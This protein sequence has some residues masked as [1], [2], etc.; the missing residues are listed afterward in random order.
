MKR[1]TSSSPV[2]LF[3]DVQL[4]ADVPILLDGNAGHYLVN[5]MRCKEGDEIVLFNGF[6]GE[7]VATIVQVGK[8]KAR[9]V[10]DTQR[11]M[12]Q[13]E[14]DL[15]LLFAPIKKARLDY[16]IQKATEL[17]AS[18]IQAVLTQRTNLDRVKQDRMQANAI[19]AAEQCERMTVPEVREPVALFKVLEQWPDDRT[20]FFCDEGGNAMTIWAAG[21]EREKLLPKAAI[22]IGPEGGFSDDERAALRALPYV[23]PITLGPRILRADTAA[24]AAMALYQSSMG[25]WC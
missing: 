9:L 8:G 15:W 7:W 25:D 21:A 20:L 23:V 14:G 6:D 17:G 3:V 11:Q 19:E 22:L 13:Q 2:R 5:V 4:Q 10:V 16:M 1:A 18:L 24:V 12:Q